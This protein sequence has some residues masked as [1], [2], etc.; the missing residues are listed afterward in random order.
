MDAMR[1]MLVI[2]MLALVP[3]GVV[4]SA[5]AG[6]TCVSCGAVGGC[7]LGGAYGICSSGKVFDVPYCIALGT[8][9]GGGSEGAADDPVMRP[10]RGAQPVARAGGAGGRSPGAR[11]P[12]AP[13]EDTRL[14]LFALRL[15]VGN[16]LEPFA[17]GVDSWV[18]RGVPGAVTPTGMLGALSRHTGL[19][20]DR[21]PVI[22]ESSSIGPGRFAAS[23]TAADGDG[24]TLRAESVA[25][26]TRVRVCA[27][28][29][30]APSGRLAD[31]MLQDG[32]LLVVRVH[33]G[34]HDYAIALTPRLDPAIEVESGEGARQQR[35][36]FDRDAGALTARARDDGV[37]FALEELPAGA[38]P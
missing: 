15:P 20:Q 6:V 36:L 25:G 37:R 10:R 18:E 8:C 11:L 27:I 3:V 31:A 2:G 13:A 34:G 33:G 9:T 1:R 22:E 38:C 23:F 30:H 5:A 4:V 32:D 24:Y 21:I 17:P 26:G 29:G 19:G 28:R 12:D 14:T 7:Q 16:G 35:A